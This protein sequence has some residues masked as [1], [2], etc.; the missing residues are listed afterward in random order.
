MQ[1]ALHATSLRTLEIGQG[2]GSLPSHK[3]RTKITALTLLKTAHKTTTAQKVLR[4]N[5]QPKPSVALLVRL[6]KF[7]KT[8]IWNWVCSLWT[9]NCQTKTAQKL[10][11]R[12]PQF[13]G[14]LG[15]ARAARCRSN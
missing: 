10:T 4:S 5:S 8:V 9:P 3:V 15:L 2:L 1:I 12:Q 14:A 11:S 7:K 6:L 13:L